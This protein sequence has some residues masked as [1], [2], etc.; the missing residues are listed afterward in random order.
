MRLGA[1]PNEAMKLYELAYA[2]SLYGQDDAEYRGMRETLGKNPD[3]ASPEQQDKLLQF[4]NEWKCRI[5]KNDFPKLK[6]KLQQWW[7]E[8]QYKLPGK[9]IRD[10][11]DSERKQ[12]ESAYQELLNYGAGLRFQDTAAAK[13]LHILR[14]DTLPMWDAKIKEWFTH[15]VGKT[16]SDFVRHVAVEELSELE[17]DVERLGYSLNEVPQLVHSAAVDVSLVKLVDEY[18]FVTKT[19]GYNVP[20]REQADKWLSWMPK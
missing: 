14:P 5:A 11:D 7:A 10:L 16:Y 2:C 18:Y 1:T 12:I 8:N 20:T 17:K 15:I 13:T 9:N 19:L 3:L 4:L 6:Q